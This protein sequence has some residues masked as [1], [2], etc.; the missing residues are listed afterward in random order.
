[1]V[2]SDV[3]FQIMVLRQYRECEGD[4]RMGKDLETVAA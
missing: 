4:R 3:D 2:P 1:M